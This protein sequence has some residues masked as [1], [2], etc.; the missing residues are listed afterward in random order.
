MIYERVPLSASALA[1]LPSVCVPLRSLRLVSRTI[2]REISMARVRALE[3]AALSTNTIYFL[4]IHDFSRF[5]PVRLFPLLPNM[6][7][8]R[9]ISIGQ[10]GTYGNTAAAD[11]PARRWPYHTFQLASLG[12]FPNLRHIVLGVGSIDCMPDPRDRHW[13]STPRTTRVYRYRR[14]VQWVLRNWPVMPIGLVLQLECYMLAYVPER[15][16]VPRRDFRW[17]NQAQITLELECVDFNMW[18]ARAPVVESESQQPA[19]RW[20]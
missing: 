1:A 3:L 16:D 8:V 4:D 12:Y 14:V 13:L 18:Q 19:P 5:L 17:P 9:S 20:I 6:S 2:H 7:L 11:T 15:T 10:F